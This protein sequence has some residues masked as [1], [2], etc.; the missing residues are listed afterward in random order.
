MLDVT[1][2]IRAVSHEV[3]L[4]LHIIG[5]EGVL[6]LCICNLAVQILV[7]NILQSLKLCLCELELQDLSQCIAECLNCDAP[8]V[9][10]VT[11]PE[12]SFRCD[13]SAAELSE[14]LS[15]SNS[16]R[17]LFEICAPLLD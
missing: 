13:L 11:N 8:R 4:L 16:I 5:F 7:E 1:A 14:E 2:S 10:L 3:V 6:E 9:C 15:Q 12:E 17:V